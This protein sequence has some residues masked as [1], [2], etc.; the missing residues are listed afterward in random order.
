MSHL[1]LLA[2]VQVNVLYQSERVISIMLRMIL[3]F[4]YERAHD[5]R[6]QSSLHPQKAVNK[7][8]HER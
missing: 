1:R 3:Y 8:M 5:L 2:K 7:E 6:D 4:V